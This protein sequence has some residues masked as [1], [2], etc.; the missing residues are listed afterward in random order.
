VSERERPPIE[1]VERGGKEGDPWNTDIVDR[2]RIFAKTI[3]SKFVTNGK[4]FFTEED[5]VSD[6]DLQYFAMTDAIEVIEHYRK[7][8]AEGQ[9]TVRAYQMLALQLASEL[10]V[11]C[12]DP[13]EHVQQVEQL[14]KEM[15][16]GK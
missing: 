16:E 1:D 15:K 6:Q 14:K 10:T 5:Q 13:E 2:L 11:Y 4:Y 3:N 12:P 9:K 8:L 7:Q